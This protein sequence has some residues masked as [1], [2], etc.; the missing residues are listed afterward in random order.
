M[1]ISWIEHTAPPAHELRLFLKPV[2]ISRHPK[3]LS[4]SHSSFWF[5]P[6][7]I[8]SITNDHDEFFDLPFQGGGSPNQST[9]DFR[10][11]PRCR[12]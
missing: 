9:G 5:C 12:R 7:V 4:P 8:S 6:P 10:T 3:L 11:I 2:F 1:L